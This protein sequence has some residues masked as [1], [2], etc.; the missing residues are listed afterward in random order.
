MRRKG[1]GKGR[2][3]AAARAPLSGPGR[4]G[5]RLPLAALS[6]FGPWRFRGLYGPAS[7]PV[8]RIAGAVLVRTVGPAALAALAAW[9]PSTLPSWTHE[10]TSVHA[11]ERDRSPEKRRPR[12]LTAAVMRLHSHRVCLITCRE[13]WLFLRPSSLTHP[14]LSRAW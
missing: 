7:W 9:Y 2:S 4:K 12:H 14:L 6:S 10:D 3:P 1:P 11:R 5:W 8:S 13:T